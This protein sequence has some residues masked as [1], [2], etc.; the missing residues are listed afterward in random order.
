M[1]FILYLFLRWRYIYTVFRT[2]YGFVYVTAKETVADLP[3]AETFAAQGI[4]V[5]E[6]A[7]HISEKEQQD[8]QYGYPSQQITEPCRRTKTECGQQGG[9]YN[10]QQPR[11]RLEDSG[12]RAAGIRM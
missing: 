2:A 5:F 1:V 7:K 11:K 9:K 4:T 3:Q 12:T 8:C 6:Q 10:S